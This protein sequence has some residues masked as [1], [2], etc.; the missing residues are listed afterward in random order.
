MTV[1]PL[2]IAISSN[3]TRL[4]LSTLVN[5]LIQNGNPDWNTQPFDFLIDGKLV[6][7]SL[8][9]FLLAKS[10]S[11]E[12]ILEIEYIKAV[13]TRKEEEPS[14]HDDWVSSVDGSDPRFIVTGCY[15]SLARVWKAARECT[16]ILEGHSDVIASVGVINRKGVQEY[17]RYD[18]IH[19]FPFFVENFTRIGLGHSLPSLV[20]NSL[21]HGPRKSS[22]ALMLELKVLLSLQLVVLIPFLGYG[23]LVNQF[24][25]HTSW[26][27]A[28]KWHDKSWFH[29]VSSSYDGKVMLWDLRT[30]WP[31]AVIESHKDKVLCAD[32][33][34]GDT[35]FLYCEC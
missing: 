15:G 7:M 31:L 27:S 21:L 28:C 10:I 13:A 5:N 19:S 8:D 33:W 3:L 20:Y 24:L 11:V 18:A 6:R 29:L 35:E 17:W 34:K 16:H 30:A 9:K 12:K 22:T 1:P 2:P 26:I 32:W 14:L 23:I 4:G 25:S